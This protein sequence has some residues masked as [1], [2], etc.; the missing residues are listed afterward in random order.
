MQLVGNDTILLGHG[1]GQKGPHIQFPADI[2]FIVT[3]R[4][5]FQAGLQCFCEILIAAF[6]NSRFFPLNFA[7]SH[8]GAVIFIG[9][10]A[11]FPE[12]LC[13]DIRT[14]LKYPF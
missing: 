8:I 6:L 12:N 2:V 4:H 1:F 3:I 5:V 14:L 9:T 11:R 7:Y 13:I 10:A